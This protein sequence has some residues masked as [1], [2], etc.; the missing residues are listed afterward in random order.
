MERPAYLAATLVAI[1]AVN[2]CD[3]RSVRPVAS[4][5]TAPSSAVPRGDI[6]LRSISPAS[7]A[8]LS[9][10]PCEW[11][12]WYV[13]VCADRSPMTFDV[14]Y[15]DAVSEA[16]LTAAFYDGTQ[17]CGIAYSATPGPALMG[18][19][20]AVS[21]T[22]SI[23]SLSDEDHP[24]LCRLPATTTRMVVELWERGRPATPL[25]TKVFD[26]TYTFIQ[27]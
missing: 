13:D 1:L 14:Q 5:P 23:I 8:T 19:S 11:Y 4:T 18:G 12:S 22:A 15:P 21:F 2:A 9:V 27:P 20:D 10:R 6:T 16:V 7:G 25:L 17:R 3:D 26:H 24:L